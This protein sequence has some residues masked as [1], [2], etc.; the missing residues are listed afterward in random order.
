MILNTN[1]KNLLSSTSLVLAFLIHG[2]AASA[3]SVEEQARDLMEKYKPALVVVT[4]T[5]TI[6]TTTSGK[7]LPPK[8]Q[9]RRTLGMTVG[10]DGLIAVSNSSIDSSVGLASQKAEIEG[11]IVEITSAKT[12][13]KTIEI[14]YGDGTVLDGKVVRQD[15]SADVAFILPDSAEAKA[16]GKEFEKIDLTQFAA[17]VQAGDQ[18]VGLSRSSSV[19]GY[20]PT[21]LI[22][23]ITGVFKGDRTFF[24]TTNG[25][26]QGMPLFTLDGKPVGM[27]VVRVID[28]QPTG[29]LA[30]LSAGSIQVMANLARGN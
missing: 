19:F 30:T 21:L 20:M 9:Q 12:E 13:F 16:V 10:D 7:E 18:V 22:G 26:S 27:V 29:I 24:I 23:R 3:Q 4:V 17:T 28:G 8:E 5:G 11:E 6:L 1:M 2:T 25:N 14:S 15:V